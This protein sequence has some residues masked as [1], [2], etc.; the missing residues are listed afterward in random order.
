MDVQENTEGPVVLQ[1]HKLDPSRVQLDVSEYS[2]AFLS[3]TRELLL[4]H[5]YQNEALLLPLTKGD[6][7]SITCESGRYEHQEHVNSVSSSSRRLDSLENL[8]GT[9]GSV[10]G[11]SD[12]GFSPERN[13]SQ[14]NTCPFISDVNSLAWGSCGDMYKQHTEA[15]F[16]EFLFVVGERGV[17][18]HAFR[19]LK[20]SDELVQPPIKGANEVGKWMNWGPSSVSSYDNKTVGD[21]SMASRSSEAE[22]RP[23]CAG[24]DS[25]SHLSS[26][27][28]SKK[29]LQTFMSSAETMESE[30]IIMTR[31]PEKSKLPCAAY[32]VSFPVS[33]NESCFL[34]FISDARSSLNDGASEGKRIPKPG[35]NKTSVADLRFIDGNF[36]RSI[37]YVCLRVFSSTFGHLIGFVLSTGCDDSMD[38]SY[39]KPDIIVIVA[40]VDL[41]G[42]QWLYS[43]KLPQTDMSSEVEWVDFQIFDKF[44]V[45]LN[46]FGSVFLHGATTGEYIA[47]VNLLQIYG[48]HPI[49][50]NVFINGNGV[51]EDDLLRQKLDSARTIAGKQ[52]FR[53]LIGAPYSSCFTVVD[54][55]GV[56]YIV[57]ATDHVPDKYTMVDKLLPQYLRLGLLA[58]WDVG[59]S[60]I[61]QQKILSASLVS[62]KSVNFSSKSQKLFL[63]HENNYFQLESVR[64]WHSQGGLNQDDLSLHGFSSVPHNGVKNISDSHHPHCNRRFFLPIAR[65]DTADTICF[66]NLGITRLI[67]R[68]NLRSERSYIAHTSLYIEPNCSDDKCLGLLNRTFDVQGVD[69]DAIGCNFQGCLYLITRNAVSVV[70]PSVSVPLNFHR[71]HLMSKNNESEGTVHNLQGSS[72]YNGTKPLVLPW[73]VAVLDRVILYEGPDE[74]D[75]L[76]LQNNWDLKVSRLCRLQL[77]LTYLMFEEIEQALEMLAEV[78]IAEEG[79]LRLIFAA[80]YTMVHKVGN[81]VEV[82]AALRLLSLGTRFCIKMLRRLAFI[83]LQNK[84]EL[85]RIQETGI[86]LLPR[87]LPCTQEDDRSYS[88]R[89]HELSYY[90][91]IIRNIQCQLAAKYKRPGQGAIEAWQA[92]DLE[93]QQSSSLVDDQLSIGRTD[94]I[95]MDNQDQYESTTLEADMGFRDPENLALVPVNSR[96][97]DNVDHSGIQDETSVVVAGSIPRRKLPL[98]NP[99]DMFA[100]WEMNNLDLKTVVKDAL[101]SG[102]LPLAVLQLHLHQ[103]KDLVNDRKQ[104]DT[105]AEVREIGRTIA[106]ELLLKG[107]TALAVT[108]LQKLGEDI[109]TCLKQLLYG[110]VSRSLRNQIGEEVKKYGFLKSYELALLDRISLIERIYPCSS[111]WRTYA[112]R[113][114]EV[115]GGLPLTKDSRDFSLY[116]LCTNFRNHSIEC[117][118]INGVVLGSWA[119]VNCIDVSSDVGD[120]SSQG[121]YWAAAA[122]WATAWDQTTI[123]RILLDQPFLLGVHVMWESQFEY[124]VCHND[125]E[126]VSK[127][128]QMIPSSLLYDRSLFISLDDLLPASS[129]GDCVDSVDYGGYVCPPDELDAVCI[130][131]PNIKIFRS[132]LNLMC[133][134]WLKMLIGREL[135]KRFI[136]LK[137]CWVGAREFIFLLA[138]S[139]FLGGE[140]GSSIRTESVHHSAIIDSANVTEFDPITFGALHKLVV[141]YCAQNNVPHFLD[142]YLDRHKLA[143]DSD[144]IGALQDAAGDC[145][146]AKWLLF[147]RTKGHEYD[148]SFSNARALLMRD[149]ES[150]LPILDANA[151]ISTVDGIAE[152][153]WVMAALAT[154]MYAPLPIQNCISSGSVKMNCSSSQCTFENLRPVLQKFPTLWRTLFSA[155]FGQDT[156]QSVWGSKG[157]TALSVY[158]NW[159]D[160]MFY[161]SGHD[162][163]LL[164]ML[165]C[166]FPKR[167]RR[168][169]QLF[170]QGPLGWQA[171]AVS[172][173][174]PYA[175]RDI[176]ILLSNQEYSE[177]S[178]IS[179]ETAIQ[180]QIE[181]ELYPP[182][183]DTGVALEQHL[184]RGRAFAALNQLLG[185]RVQKLK[186]D[187]T[188]GSQ[189]NALTRGQANIQSDVQTLLAPLTQNEE[190]LLSS[191]IPLAITNYQDS[192]LVGS[193]AFLLELCGLS[194]SQLRVDVSVLRRISLFYKTNQVDQQNQLL[195]SGASLLGAVSDA[196]VADSLAKVLADYYHHQEHQSV[197]KQEGAEKLAKGQRLSPLMVVLQ[198]LEKASLLLNAS[199]KS[200][201]SW[202]LNG[203]GD[204]NE[205][206]SQQKVASQHWSLVSA[207]CQMHQIPLSTMYLASLARDNDWVGFL[208]EAQ[209]GGYP[210]DVVIQVAAKEFTDLRLRTHIL[211]VLRCMESKKKSIM[212]S[213]VDS[214][215]S[216]SESPFISQDIR[217]PAELFQILAQCEKQMLPG[218]A[219]LWKA[220]ELNWSLLAMIASCF[221]DVAPLPCLTV[222][223]EI[224]AAKEISSVR[225]SEVASQIANNVG[226]AVEASN[227]LPTDDSAQT[228][229]YNRKSP[230]RRRLIDQVSDDFYSASTNNI[231]SVHARLIVE[232]VKE[233]GMDND[234]KLSKDSDDWPISLPKLVALLCQ[235]HQFLPLLRAFEMFLPSCCLLPFIRALQ[236]FS[237]MRLSEASAHL[238]SFSSR[239]KEEPFLLTSNFSKQGLSGTSW[240]SSTAVMA[241]DAIISTSPSPYEKR[242]LLQLLVST[243]FGDGGSAAANYQRQL[244]KIN[245]AEPALRKHEDLQLGNKSLDD[246]SLL[247]ALENN[248]YW[249]Q[250]RNWA[251]QLEAS[252]GPW[253]AA[254]HRVTERQAAAMVAEW[255]EFLWD[256]AEERIALWRHCQNLFIRYS[257]PA[258]Q[259]GWFFFK[260][261]E[262]VEKELPPRELHELLLLS[263][264][265]LSGT[266]TNSH[267]SCP[268]HLLREIETRLWLLAVESEAQLKGERGSTLITSSQ[269]Q[270]CGNS[271]NIIDQTAE[272]IAKMDSHMNMMRSRVSEKGDVRENSSSQHRSPQTWDTGVSGGTKNKRR[273]KAY[274][275]TRRF[276]AE[277]ADR[278]AD[279][280]ES[281]FPSSDLG[282]DLLAEH[283]RLDASYSSWQERVGHT[284]IERAVLSLLEFGQVTAAKQLQNK[285]S[286]GSMPF[287]LRIVDA[288]LKVAELS[289][290]LQKQSLQILDEDL[291]SLIQSD[292]MATEDLL[293]NPLQIL[294]NLSA[295]LTEGSGR[296]LCK[297]IIAVVKAANVLGILFLE[298]FEKQPTELLQL[299]SLKAQDSFDEARLVVQSHSMPATSI[300]NILAES[301]LKGLLAAHRGGYIDS[302]KEEGPSPLLWRFS[303][304]LKWAELCPSEQEIGHALMRLVI[305]GQEIPHACEVELL[306]LSHH[307]YQSSACLDG[308]DVLVALA[309]TRVEAY[310]SEGDFSCLA[311]LIT[312]VG[313]FHALN[314]ILG[315]LIENGQLD[316]L[317]QKFS[318][319]ADA[320]TGVAKAV[321]GFRMAVVTALKHFNPNDLDAFATVYNH[322]DM[323]HET[324]SLLE[325]RAKQSYQQWHL[326]YDKDQ[327]EDLL[328]SMRFYIEAAEVYSSID[329]GDKT[330]SSCAQASLVSLQIRMP[331]IRWLNLSETS[332]RRLLVEQ[333]R[334]QE[335]L[336]VA[337]AYNLNQPSEWTP[338]LWNQMLK[339][340]VAE[341]FVAE[342]VA[343]LPLHHTTLIELA[344]FYR[345]EMVA[346]GDQSHFSV[347][348]TGGGLPAEWAKYLGRS[349]RC[350]LKRT[351]DLTWRL[352]MATL[353]TGF[354]DVTDACNK[355]L[356]KVPEKA[357]PLVLRKGHGGA[358]LP[359]T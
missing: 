118:D 7:Y 272:V 247:T 29:W 131:I 291:Y 112:F 158:I 12:N 333:S 26:A 162:T 325:S 173:E 299:L 268:L 5:S 48:V 213:S 46:K 201:G 157:R 316:L 150:S 37:P 168:L 60:D 143:L 176:E 288:A 244:W 225:E 263:I 139:G 267:P 266:I 116:L 177:I 61:G 340:E 21:V 64:N 117:D 89:L 197:N 352:Q 172:G 220:K 6:P 349:F 249:E 65:F 350:L 67:R 11:V 28:P 74:A 282:Y 202:L 255:K 281:S 20:Y 344:K 9:S 194:V 189:S 105:F 104:S 18:V 148:A 146:W 250:A 156:N 251:R 329:S 319:A 196:T 106:Y 34:G 303:D 256:V 25:A 326:R 277:V 81:D 41:F 205:L 159:R 144:S 142:L 109:E 188:D 312:G 323:K 181:Q 96:G 358:Y 2:E 91:E 178:A 138:Q 238:G 226:A 121:G 133:S 206:R 262:A 15:P 228:L 351:R 39:K 345:S 289:T 53:R 276:T 232:D 66:S 22:V 339:P 355:A 237:Q 214:P 191:V 264:Q 356:D 111:F 284:E 348:L 198:H 313:N 62:E 102:R 4:L 147:S 273:T 183:E 224:S 306:I 179:W 97:S 160:S 52:R 310:V 40:L 137:E 125:W 8:P 149:G 287:E 204:G 259:A 170:V 330:R 107:D 254:V 354:N 135:A 208:S 253:K 140:I 71:I 120:D 327:N 19:Q 298:A 239:I 124:H 42:L 101:M 35:D 212:L 235:Q 229:H 56:A 33:F 82:P 243:D 295:I 54:E 152:A 32:V 192:M 115:V 58:P 347:W 307:F 103:L 141:H 217:S 260:H 334:F 47:Y 211:T 257:F 73:Q 290:P 337:E 200:C 123:D 187:G 301:F 169:I 294:E 286:S 322:F 285:L 55:C 293:A 270:M 24:E 69:G 292:D 90:L 219:L 57:C 335:A 184:H 338:V 94:G 328:E 163:S 86:L 182:V 78:N 315:I 75:R 119:N 216:R 38:C 221:P 311:R 279:V 252:G 296:G 171:T 153:G 309:A 23:H 44:L 342:F 1:L 154:L 16:R 331:D 128:L 17:T 136:F 165:P 265:W 31:F 304:F 92:Q 261:E 88:K 218:K 346:R 70:L 130:E 13:I 110:T 199:E 231:S 275:P 145:Q 357:G 227:A 151:I 207:F 230:K 175:Q 36:A 343:V 190:F 129:I 258:L 240:I 50:A 132:P 321:R 283:L 122:V 234:V 242:C 180:K 98:E 85:Q 186:S 246:A 353:A 155:C 10:E 30:G 134:S 341:Q 76:C 83:E 241:A 166:W 236:A 113:K 300:A 80:I 45:S 223:L 87:S 248:G 308:V 336:I 68:K 3:P 195:S 185:Y 314:F 193:C 210:S 49:Q 108:T 332:A 72:M 95:L 271:A 77:A 100:R 209:V 324:A 174:D 203:D 43:I 222:W 27:L 114:K 84:C 63:S 317:L 305:T 359:V 79:I 167:L 280:D 320:N 99:N 297:R 164:Q 318:A 278:I 14:S 126:E 274:G 161:S 127:L 93:N 215:E 233:I 59:Y 51:A 302:Q 245:L 269:Y